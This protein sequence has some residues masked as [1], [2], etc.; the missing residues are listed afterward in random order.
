M[1]N[2]SYSGGNFS[3]RTLAQSGGLGNAKLGQ[4]H[5]FRDSWIAAAGAVDKAAPRPYF[6]GID[7]TAMALI[8]LRFWPLNPEL[9]NSHSFGG[10]SRVR[11]ATQRVTVS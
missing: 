4:N 5:E 11:T 1:K 2:P 7:K 3:G 6:S 8:L 9:L 10:C